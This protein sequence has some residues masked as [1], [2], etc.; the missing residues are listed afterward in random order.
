[1]V[2]LFAPRFFTVLRDVAAE[3]L[4]VEDETLAG[5][6]AVARAGGPSAAA[7][8][9]DALAVLEPHL[10]ERILEATHRRLRED[11]AAMLQHWSPKPP[12]RQ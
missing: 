9:Q 11:P 8:A 10:R 6:D 1:M 4:G 2:D 5:F 3:H 12:H 7:L